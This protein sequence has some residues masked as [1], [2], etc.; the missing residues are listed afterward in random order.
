MSCLPIPDDLFWVVRGARGPQKPIY[1]FF[2][3]DVSGFHYR[4]F[5]PIDL[6]LDFHGFI[7]RRGFGFVKTV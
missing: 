6:R 3:R 5:M 4:Q 2:A 1:F 7:D